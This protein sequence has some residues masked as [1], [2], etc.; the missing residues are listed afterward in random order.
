MVKSRTVTYSSAE[1][2][3]N[4]G[5]HVSMRTGARMS[6]IVTF[7]HDSACSL[8][9]SGLSTK[10]EDTQA[11]A[12]RSSQAFK[13][14]SRQTSKQANKQAGKQASRQK[15]TQAGKQ[16]STRA[17]KFWNAP[18]SSNELSV[19]ETKHALLRRC[20]ICC[21][22]GVDDRHMMTSRYQSSKERCLR[23]C[24]YKQTE[25]GCRHYHIIERV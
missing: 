4:R 3:R 25:R 17:S 10:Q 16:A 13:Q 5:R 12:L 11:R 2:R 6:R 18:T 15:S 1:G 19:H 7:R 20:C 14:A 8:K 24:M 23:K 9:A 22:R 21:C